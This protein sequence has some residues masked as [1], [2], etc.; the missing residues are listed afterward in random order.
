MDSKLSRR[1]KQATYSQPRPLTQSEIVS[2][3]QDAI[4]TS[5]TMKDLIAERKL[6]QTKAVT[7]L[8]AP[9]TKIAAE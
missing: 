9:K 3:R 2:L 4:S 5:T 8:V 6:R 1:E 7:A